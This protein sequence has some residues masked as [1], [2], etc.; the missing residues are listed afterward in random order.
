MKLC[1]QLDSEEAR[2]HIIQ[3]RDGVLGIDAI[4]QMT[5]FIPNRSI[6]KYSRISDIEDLSQMAYTA[7]IV[8]IQ[9]FP[10]NSTIDFFGWAVQ[11]IRREIIA[12]IRKQKRCEA[13]VKRARVAGETLLGTSEH[14]ECAYINS[15]MDRRIAVAMGTLGTKARS[16]LIDKFSH[17]NSDYATESYFKRKK[18]LDRAM[19][20]ISGFDYLR[21]YL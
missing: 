19:K 13:A 17:N 14:P 12:F 6:R 21:E 20:H 7:H 4:F 10:V 18:Q 8:A 11:T 5:M 9:T 15:E 2:A 16:A 3:L 1:K